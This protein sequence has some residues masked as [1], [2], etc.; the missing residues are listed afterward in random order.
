MLAEPT[1]ASSAGSVWQLELFSRGPRQ[2][3]DT[4]RTFH[5]NCQMSKNVENR[6]DA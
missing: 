2:G 6:K 5:G 4:G 3:C 1:R